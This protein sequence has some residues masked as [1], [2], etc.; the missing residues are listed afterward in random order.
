MIGFLLVLA[1]CMPVSWF[2]K[3]NKNEIDSNLI[4]PIAHWLI[5]KKKEKAINHDS[6][7]YSVDAAIKMLQK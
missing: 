1:V 4:S 7:Y 3:N 6:V 5:F 2:T